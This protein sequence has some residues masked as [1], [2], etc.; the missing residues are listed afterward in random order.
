MSARTG[1]GNT[2]GRNI[3]IPTEVWEAA[4]ARADAEGTHVSAV[5]VTAL[6]KYAAKQPAAGVRR[7][8]QS[9]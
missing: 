8:G 6:T 5:I 3:R 4:K 2:P 7:S 1:K 9:S